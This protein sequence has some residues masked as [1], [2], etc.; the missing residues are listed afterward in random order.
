MGIPE[1]RSS[2]TS[3]LPMKP[4][5]P[6]IS[7][8]LRIGIASWEACSMVTAA[9]ALRYHRSSRRIAGVAVAEFDQFAS[10]YKSVLDRSVALAGES[11]EYFT[12]YKA[13]YLDRLL[14]DRR[15][16][17]I[18]DFGCGIGALSSALARMRPQ[19]RIHGFDVSEQ[20]LDRVDADL[21]RRGLFT[22]NPDDLHRDYDMILLSNVM[23]HI[24][25]HARGA[26]VNDLAARLAS[27]GRL[28]VFEHNPLNPLTRWVVAHCEFDDD[29][30]LLWPREV[31]RYLLDAKLVAPRRNYLVFFPKALSL[32]RGL[33]QTLG[34]C[35]AGAQYALTASKA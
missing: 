1:R 2:P 34:W 29:A 3:R 23:H 21:R 33:E 26:T 8:A 4:P 30:Q 22:S 14:G 35:P 24:P 32:L 18:L 31:R 5:P 13:A 15:N 28:V 12:L 25:V 17:K 9:N 27:G 20:S 11:F 19:D 7:V 6:R 16:S 10:N